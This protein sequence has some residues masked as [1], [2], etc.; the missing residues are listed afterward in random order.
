M[1]PQLGGGSE[2]SS[3]SSFSACEESTGWMRKGKI[4]G[5]WSQ[6]EQDGEGKGTVECR[7]SDTGSVRKR[8]LGTL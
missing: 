7:E 1:L 2:E 5:E 8:C 6:E 3:V 4:R